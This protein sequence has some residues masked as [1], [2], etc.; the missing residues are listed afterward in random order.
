[1]REGDAMSSKRF[2]LLAGLLVLVMACALPGLGAPAEVSEGQLATMVAGTAAAMATQTALAVPPTETPLP[3]PT[4][5]S[6]P[7]ETPLP[8]PT[9]TA[10]ISALSQTSLQGMADGSVQFMDY[11]A[12][13]KLFAP[14]GW[15]VFRINE[16]EYYDLWASELVNNPAI[17][18]FLGVIQ[19]KNPD[20]F[21][22]ILLDARDE[23]LDTGFVNYIDV[24]YNPNDIRTLEE[25]TEDEKKADAFVGTELISEEYGQTSTGL[26]NSTLIK[27]F[28]GLTDANETIKVYYKRVY[29]R[30]ADGIIAIGL[31]VPDEAKDSVLPEFDQM[32]DSLMILE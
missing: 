9:P 28:D 17:S 26:E 8:S 23:H 22:L 32:V 18:D 27:Q 19:T 7:T 6:A 24:V 10:M 29:F 15:T 2:Y 4:A 30:V 11:K 5:T 3:S 1:M 12:G 21:R 31:Q 16:Q 14:A 13:V 25:A 20:H